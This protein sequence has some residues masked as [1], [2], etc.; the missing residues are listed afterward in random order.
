MRDRVSMVGTADRLKAS[1]ARCV[2]ELRNFM[3]Y[4]FESVFVFTVPLI[5]C[6]ITRSNFDCVIFAKE[7]QLQPNSFILFRYFARAR[8]KIKSELRSVTMA[9]LLCNSSESMKCRPAMY[10]V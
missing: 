3:C 8:K 4:S 2:V 1:R 6:D 7:A 10:H 5:K 9:I